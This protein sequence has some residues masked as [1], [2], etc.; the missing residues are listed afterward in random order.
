MTAHSEQVATILRVLGW[1]AVDPD[2]V[3]WGGERAKARDALDSL[4]AALTQAQDVAHAEAERALDLARLSEE[5]LAALTQAQ[6]MEEALREYASH[7]AWRCE[8]RTRYEACQCGL[9]DTL[10][11]LGL[12]PVPVDDPEARK[13]Q[14]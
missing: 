14:G 2:P 9:D 7:Q 1:D 12:P 5:Q 10:A 4:A 8:Y 3:T 6:Q 11:K 13:D